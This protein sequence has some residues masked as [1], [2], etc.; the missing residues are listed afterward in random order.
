[1]LG[2]DL[3]L[4]TITL[5]QQNSLITIKKKKKHFAF[6]YIIITIEEHSS[7]LKYFIL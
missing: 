7:T 3:K 4:A 1:M 6:E 2:K 5:C